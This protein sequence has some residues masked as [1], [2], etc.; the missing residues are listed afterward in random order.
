ML[1]EKLEKLGYK[2]VENRLYE[3]ALLNEYGYAYLY[4]RIEV[5]DNKVTDYE[6]RD[7]NATEYY[8]SYAFKNIEEL[9]KQYE[10]FK[11]G[12]DILNNDIKEIKLWLEEYFI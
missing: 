12:L 5:T 6:V 3:K 1:K 4:L 10:V 2:Q 8:S 7:T 9:N 11:K